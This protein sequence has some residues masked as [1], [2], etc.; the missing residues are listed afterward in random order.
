MPSY[1]LSLKELQ[2]L[3][4]GHVRGRVRNDKEDQSAENRWNLAGTD[5]PIGPHP[6][7]TRL[8][9]RGAFTV[10]DLSVTTFAS[11]LPKQIARAANAPTGNRIM[12]MVDLDELLRE[13]TC[14][15]Q[16]VKELSLLNGSGSTAHVET[17]GR[18]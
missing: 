11:P 4:P 15:P 9:R 17:A 10:V 7:R 18:T 8:D 2:D 13:K 5:L 3:T 16:C 6:K 14:C 1:S 12:N